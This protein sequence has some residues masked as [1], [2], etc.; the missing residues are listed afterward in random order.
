MATKFHTLSQATKSQPKFSV[1]AEQSFF[2]WVQHLQ[3][4][5]TSPSKFNGSR[6]GVLTTPSIYTIIN[7]LSKV[8]NFHIDHYWRATTNS[9]C[10]I[11]YIKHQFFHRLIRRQFSPVD[12]QVVPVQQQALTYEEHNALHYTAG[13]VCCTLEKRLTES[14]HPSKGDL[15]IG[16]GD[17]CC[18]D[19][20]EDDE[21]DAKEWEEL[22]D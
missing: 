13:A 2:C 9:L 1:F 3:L 20:N 16:I 8:V 11:Q 19:D 7:L 18:D 14:K 21:N 22:I 4:S 6:Y 15:L 10:Y 17:L 12:E 5:P